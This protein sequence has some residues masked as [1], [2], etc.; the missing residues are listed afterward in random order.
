[1]NVNKSKY[2]PFDV[3]AVLA[4]RSKVL[5]QLYTCKYSIL[6]AHGA[7]ELDGSVHA[8]GHVDRISNE[9][10]SPIAACHFNSRGRGR[11]ITLEGI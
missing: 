8:T 6:T 1:M 11:L 7:N 10:F 3:S 4:S 5:C 2:V 9:D